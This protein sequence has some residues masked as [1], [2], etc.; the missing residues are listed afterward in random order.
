MEER[1]TKSLSSKCNK[2][3]A[4]QLTRQPSESTRSRERSWKIDTNVNRYFIRN[5]LDYPNVETSKPSK[6]YVKAMKHLHVSHFCPFICTCA[7]LLNILHR[8]L[9]F[10]P[11]HLTSNSWTCYDG[12]SFMTLR[13]ASLPSKHLSIP[14]SRRPSLT[15]APKLS[16]SVASFD[17]TFN[18]L[19]SNK[20]T[21]NPKSKFFSLF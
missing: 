8:T 20:R 1:S 16:E 11:L 15:M 3:A 18:K 14:G 2:D 4:T 10:P 5:R 12:Y 6:K 21:H 17:G 7:P 19:R 9:S 13:T